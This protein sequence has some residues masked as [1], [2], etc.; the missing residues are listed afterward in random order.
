MVVKM[1]LF[2]S[3][4][5]FSLPLPHRRNRNPW[6]AYPLL[7]GLTAP[8]PI[9]ATK[10][11]RV[12]IISCTGRKMNRSISWNTFSLECAITNTATSTS[13][14]NPC[15][16]ETS[17][18]HFQVFSCLS[19]LSLCSCLSV[20]VCLWSCL[21]LCSYLLITP[22]KAREILAHTLNTFRGCDKY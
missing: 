12:S 17:S 9:M 3:L 1:N 11:L 2:W 10:N 4:T 21:C 8:R 22:R 18:P 6:G 16:N 14:L 20:S 19:F 5:Y 7:R 15:Y 13:I